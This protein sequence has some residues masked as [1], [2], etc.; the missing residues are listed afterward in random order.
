MNPP[1]SKLG[2]KGL[3]TDFTWGSTKP[4]PALRFTLRDFRFFDLCGRYGRF[5]GI[6]DRSNR[7]VTVTARPFWIN[8]LNRSYSESLNVES[9]L[10]S[11]NYFGP[12]VVVYP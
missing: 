4:S 2:L 11:S 12:E 1:P 7:A 3:F 10:Y 8:I 6:T 5:Y 9:K